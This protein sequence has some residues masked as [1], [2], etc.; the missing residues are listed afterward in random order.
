[1]FKQHFELKFN[2]FNKEISTDKLFSSNDSKELDS[3]LKYMLDNRG[4]C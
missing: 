1:M 2:P 4:I 3:R